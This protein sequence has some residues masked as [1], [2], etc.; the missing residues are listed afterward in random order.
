MDFVVRRH[1]LPNEG[2][3][4]EAMR[5]L[6][7]QAKK[8]VK[9]VSEDIIEGKIGKVY[10]P[11]QKVGE[12]ALPYKAK[13]VKRER[14]EAKSKNAEEREQASKKQKEDSTIE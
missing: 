12:T 11:D 14:R 5:T 4:K 6:K 9:N 8:K 2:L 3:K 7:D 13:G 1:R 10:I